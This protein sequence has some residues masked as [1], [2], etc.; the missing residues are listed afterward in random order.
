M[1]NIIG[2]LTTEETMQLRELTGCDDINNTLK[3]SADIELKIID[4]WLSGLIE[5]NAAK[6]A[7]GIVRESVL[8]LNLI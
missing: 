8:N 4:L 5:H 1:E 2:F 3:S 7:L 6:A